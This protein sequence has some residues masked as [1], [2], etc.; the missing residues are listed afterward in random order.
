MVF[1]KLLCNLIFTFLRYSPEAGWDLVYISLTR[2]HPVGLS[3]IYTW[4]Q[5]KVGCQAGKFCTH[6]HNQDNREERQFPSSTRYGLA[7][8]FPMGVKFK[9][10][11]PI[12]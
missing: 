2:Q 8:F 1:S 9:L 4:D 3:S 10:F 6:R 11:V 12:P 5:K 7:N